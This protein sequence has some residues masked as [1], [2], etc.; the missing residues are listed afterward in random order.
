MSKR[1]ERTERLLALTADPDFLDIVCDRVAEG[2]TLF[3]IARGH[4]VRYGELRNWIMDEGH[5]DRLARYTQALEARDNG[6]QDR[7]LRVLR[8]TADV[9][10][11]LAFDKD[12]ELKPMHEIP[13]SVARVL[14]SLDITHDRDGNR[15]IKMRVTD[16]LAG[17]NLLGRNQKMFVDRTELNGKLSLEDLVKA[18]M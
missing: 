9:D 7:V 2:D 17:V 13:D 6:H 15:N 14:S 1:R 16:R 5:T 12:G 10:I 11:R 4:D 8:D 3:E 18:S